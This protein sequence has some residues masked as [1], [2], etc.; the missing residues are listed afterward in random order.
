MRPATLAAETTAN[1]TASEA[2]Q[3][4]PLTTDARVVRISPLV[5]AA[6]RAERRLEATVVIDASDSE[7]EPD[8]DYDPGPPPV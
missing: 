7:P 2:G 6:A 3:S 4:R 1:T 5:G 8:D